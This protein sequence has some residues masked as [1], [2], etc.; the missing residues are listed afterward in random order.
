MFTKCN[1][2]IFEL[3]SVL[4][5][6]HYYRETMESM[7]VEQHYLRSPLRPFADLDTHNNNLS[8]EEKALLAARSQLFLRAAAA[9][10]AG[11]AGPGAGT[12]AGPYGP[13]VTSPLYGA[14][15]AAGV[16][17]GAVLWGQW[18][19]C[20]APSLLQ[21]HQLAMAAAAA[22][23]TSAQMAP[24]RPLAQHRYSPYASPAPQTTSRSP[25]VSSP[26]TSLRDVADP[27]LPSPPSS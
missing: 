12:A 21:Q 9:A 3:Q 18:A 16:P 8:L 6:E 4:N 19:S 27:D 25:P 20:L 13:L 11:G 24:I 22:A 26:D 10:A 2:I 23:G 17:P 1:N 14:A 7:L 5:T 15:A